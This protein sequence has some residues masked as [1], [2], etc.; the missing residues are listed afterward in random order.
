MV[1]SIGTSTIKASDLRLAPVARLAPAAASPTMQQ[2]ATSPA[3]PATTL[4][5]SMAAEPP[6][7]TNRVAAIKTAIAN[8][9]FPLSPST[10]ADQL[11]ALKYEWMSNE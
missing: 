9:T 6:V 5:R 8:G 7:D 11:I 4:A 3:A 2:T 1:D 10:I